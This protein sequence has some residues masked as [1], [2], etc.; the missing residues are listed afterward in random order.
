MRSEKLNGVYWKDLDGVE[1]ICSKPQ[2]SKK[3]NTLHIFYKENEPA[4][5]ACDSHDPGG[6]WMYLYGEIGLTENFDRKCQNM[7]RK[8]ECMRDAFFDFLGSDE[9]RFIEN[10][11]IT[12]TLD[13]DRSLV[14]TIVQ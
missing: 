5:L 12:H 1:P 13:K 2:C 8:V 10:L 7:M 4:I 3:A 14:Y 11:A 6:Y 9:G